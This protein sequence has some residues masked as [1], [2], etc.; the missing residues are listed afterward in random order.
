MTNLFATQAVDNM[1]KGSRLDYCILDKI[2]Q[3]MYNFGIRF[4]H[5]YNWN[6]L[7]INLYVKKIS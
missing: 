7:Q 4:E 6:I 1:N 3:G 2:T 5:H